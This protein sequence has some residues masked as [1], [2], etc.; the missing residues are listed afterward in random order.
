MSVLEMTKMLVSFP[1]P[2]HPL[3]LTLEGNV[4]HAE[5]EYEVSIQRETGL[6]E[7]LINFAILVLV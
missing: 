2:P 4:Q 7:I 1:N 5:G 3:S 6:S